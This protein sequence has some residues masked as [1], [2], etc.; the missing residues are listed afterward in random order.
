MVATSSDQMLAAGPSAPATPPEPIECQQHYTFSFEATPVPVF[1]G[2][3]REITMV[4]P[5][6]LGKVIKTD[7]RGSRPEPDLPWG[8]DDDYDAQD[9]ED[10]ED[11]EDCDDDDE[12]K[13]AADQGPKAVTPPSSVQSGLP[14]SIP[15]TEAISSSAC[16]DGKEATESDL[17]RDA[18]GRFYPEFCVMRTSSAV[19]AAASEI[20]DSKE[21]T[22]AFA[23]VNAAADAPGY[24]EDKLAEEVCALSDIV[25]SKSG[26]G[27][28]EYGRFVKRGLKTAPSHSRDDLVESETNKV[29]IFVQES[30]PH[31]SAKG[32]EDLFFWSNALSFVKV[33]RKYAHDWMDKTIKQS[34]RYC[35]KIFA[36]RPVLSHLLFLTWCGHTV[37]L[38]YINAALYGCSRPLDTRDRDNQV[39]IVK[40]VRLFGL[41]NGFVCGRWDVTAT[42][43]FS[44]EQDGKATQKV[45]DVKSM[46]LLDIRPGPFRSRT[47]VFADVVKD[48]KGRVYMVKLSWIAPHLT[49]HELATLRDMRKDFGAD[50]ES[51]LPLLPEPIGLANP[52]AGFPCTTSEMTTASSAA[53]EFP[54]RKL[55]ALLTKQ[56][57]GDY[58]GKQVRPHCLV[59]IHRQLA[60]VILKLASKGYHYRDLNDGNV[61]VLRGTP[62]TLYLADFGNVS[63][64]LSRRGHRDESDAAATID[65][66][67]DDTRSATPLFMP[68]CYAIAK[69]ASDHWDLAVKKVIDRAAELSQSQSQL[70]SEVSA[71]GVDGRKA[72]N[73]LGPVVDAILEQMKELQASL[74]RSNVY[75]HRYIDDLEGALYL[76]LWSMALNRGLDKR[77]QAE[78][79]EKLRT[80]KAEIWGSALMW[81]DLIKLY[82][83][84]TGKIWR[85]CMVALRQVVHDA[86]EKLTADLSKP[87]GD[88]G[89]ASLKALEKEVEKWRS[90]ASDHVGADAHATVMIIN[91][92][93]QNKGILPDAKQGL[94]QIEKECF[95]KCIA[96]LQEAGDSMQQGFVKNS[97]KK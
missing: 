26:A 37:R 42:K 5:A 96:L 36:Y 86:R 39:E 19:H 78:L 71:A 73:R 24:N 65:R 18:R 14:S 93:W 7:D 10:A 44:V 40:I 43:R 76:H 15:I 41:K 90:A 47:A 66:A 3:L 56:H 95:N 91:S 53:P 1:K 62:D 54:P 38:W 8:Q 50:L 68:C 45:V 67:K 89:A 64:D 34:M 13:D 46:Y 74:Q 82:C 20:V 92:L 35:R 4:S 2:D 72:G 32:G 31:I 25:R 55:C 69:A 61:R 63:K 85:Q 16:S 21:G 75:A 29:D 11:S 83:G 17:R 57:I 59:S 79:S 94:Q 84:P 88:E 30:A 9:S 70:S 6:L 23:N 97:K 77:G 60:D 27:Q 87:F 33:K 28:S 81:E 51:Q 48:E 80:N 12:S 52:P 58:I 49:P 22:E